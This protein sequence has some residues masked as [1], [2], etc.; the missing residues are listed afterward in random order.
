MP[1]HTNVPLKAGSMKK[2]LI[3]S[4]S[5]LTDRILRY[6]G[7][8]K[9]LTEHAETHIWTASADH[10]TGREAWQAYSESVQASP[11]PEVRAYRQIPFNYLRRMNEFAWDFKLRPPSRLSMDRH[12]RSKRM[13]KRVRAMRI[14]AWFVAKLG[15]SGWFEKMLEKL[16]LSYP[17]SPEGAKR[18]AALKPDLMVILKPFQ[19]HEPAMVRE[20]RRLNIPILALIPS[21][22]NLSTKGRLVFRYDGYMVWSDVQKAQLSHFYP[23]SRRVPSYLIGAPQFDVFHRPEFYLDRTAFC[24]Q[25]GLDPNRPI[26]LHAIGS[27]H[28]FREDYGALE[29]AKR[30]VQG[31]YGDAQLLVR[32]HPVHDKAELKQQF[33]PY[34]PR[35]ALQQTARVDLPLHRRLQTDD[36]VV[37]WINTFRHADVVVN[38]VSTVAIDAALFGKPVV[39]MNFDPEPGQPNQEILKEVSSIWT[40]YQPVMAL[41]G[42]WQAN[43]YEEIGEGIRTYLKNPELHREARETMTRFVCGFIDGRNG[44]RM[45]RAMLSFPGKAEPI[46]EGHR[47]LNQ[48]AGA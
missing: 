9:T 3:L 46:A 23:A 37:D 24:Q 47:P 18:M 6:S 16:L 45:A 27:P 30:V 33:E 31:E 11:F 14:P 7:C 19:F 48:V 43:S 25:Y 22:D 1:A 2:I 12:R 13:S 44:E 36:D 40:H 39:N 10:E 5:L 8:L 34:A 35:V 41:G 28:F 32:P 42:I 15:L 29:L 21:W 26:I 38:T 17:R 20:A 4:S